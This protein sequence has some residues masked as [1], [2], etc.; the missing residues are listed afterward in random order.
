M[1]SRKL[2]KREGRGGGPRPHVSPRRTGA[3]LHASAEIGALLETHVPLLFLQRPD[4]KA[5]GESII[6]FALIFVGI[7]FLEEL[8]WMMLSIQLVCL[9]AQ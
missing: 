6:G 5:L 3:Y 8:R 9:C 4:W 7:G 2:R 1:R